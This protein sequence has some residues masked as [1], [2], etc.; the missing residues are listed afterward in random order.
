[1]AGG[2]KVVNVSAVSGRTSGSFGRQAARGANGGSCS[3]RKT[4]VAPCP[5]PCL[6][7]SPSPPSPEIPSQTRKIL[8]I[9]R[10]RI[11]SLGGFQNFRN[12]SEARISHDS[13]ERLV[14]ERSL[15]DRGVSVLAAG[16]GS[17]R[18]VQVEEAEMIEADGGVE[19]VDH[20]VE[21]I[22]DVVAGGE[23]MAGVE[24]DA[25]PGTL[26]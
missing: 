6:P 3:L 12:I 21:A 10:H 24:A 2:R 9:F 25:D 17:L 20:L 15:S 7:T 19:F 22:T 16:E 26:L 13:P 8:R 11:I 5:C 14:T 4:S 18:I 23:D 1:M